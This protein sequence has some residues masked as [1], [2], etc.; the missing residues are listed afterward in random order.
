MIIVCFTSATFRNVI[1]G[2]EERQTETEREEL[3]GKEKEIYLHL[4]NEENVCL[5]L[6]V[7]IIL[8]RD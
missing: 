2:E 3:E 7:L 1:T 5:V 4:K 6:G 8:Y